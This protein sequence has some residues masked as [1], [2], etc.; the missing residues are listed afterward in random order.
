[1]RSLLGLLGLTFLLTTSTPA[2]ADEP[3][4]LTI[5]YA[6]H[7]GTDREKDFAGFLET[8]FRKVDRVALDRF[9][10]DQAEGHDVVV[11]DWDSILPRDASGKVIQPIDRLLYPRGAKVSESYDRPT[12]VIG[13]GGQHPIRRLRLKL[14]NLCICLGPV[15]HGIAS[16]HE[17][18][19][20]PNPVELKLEDYPTPPHY[21]HLTSGRPVGKTI[22]VWRV[23]TKRPGVDYGLVCSPWDFESSPDAEVI[24]SGVNEKTPRSVAIGRQGN[25]FFW[26]FSASPRDMTPEARKAFVNAVCYI[27]KFDGRRPI[28]HKAEKDFSREWALMYAHSLTNVFD[29][30]AFARSLPEDLRSDPAQVKRQR[31]MYLKQVEFFFPGEVRRRCGTDA[32]KYI[33]WVRDNYESIRPGESEH[34]DPP[35]IGVDEDA[36]ALGTSNRKVESLDAW[37]H[38]LERKDRAEVALRL[39]E[40]Y[41]GERF[42]DAR[43]WRSWLDANRDRLFF[44]EAGG[45]VFRVAP[46]GLTTPPRLPR[47]PL[48]TLEPTPRH[49]V[50]AEA[51]F[52]PGKARP[53]GSVWLVVRVATAPGWHITAA[54]GS[55]GRE[56]ATS[57]EL[58]LPKGFEAD[59]DW[60]LPEPTPGSG[61][62]LTYD[63]SFAFRRR[64]RL[65]ADVPSGPA[66]ASCTLRYQACDAFSCRAPDE[67]T[68]RADLSVS[69]R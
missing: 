19:R 47:T 38:R 41:T 35:Q 55:L 36:K 69:A 2:R 23:Q 11:F 4:P 15:A 34:P 13:A 12:V 56:V 54:K 1:M 63:G 50:A 58:K 27:K 48:S 64:I 52:E 51:E 65:A 10:D 43:S 44:D 9:T 31:D 59:S 5:L 67:E 22:K 28:V 24:A 16:G 20:S 3:I 29:E 49:P 17:V 68:L 53:G 46:K 14:D 39:L 42:T 62:R 57:L 7:L 61:G 18:F 66:V 21:R 40:R 32:A 45:F 6:G 26:G 30:D 37:I 33:A 60:S 25:F 8:Q